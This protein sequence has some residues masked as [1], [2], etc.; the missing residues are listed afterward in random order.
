MYFL[1]RLSIKSKTYLLVLLSVLVALT[2]SA[3]SYRGLGGL[4]AEF[5]DLVFATEIERYTNRLILEEQNYRLNANGSVYDI[6]AANRAYQNALSYVDEIYRILDEIDTLGQSDL[7]LMELEKTRQSTDEYKTLYMKAVSIL[8]EL[9]RQAD[10]LEQEGEYITLQIQQYVEAKRKEIKQVLNQKT[11]EKINNGSNI[12]QYTYVTRLHE[13]KYRLSPDPA[14]L[15]AFRKDYR[16]MMSEWHRLKAMSDQDF[17]FEKLENFYRS[18]KKYKNAMLL[19]AELD[20][21]LVND[22]LPQMKKLGDVV[23]ANAIEAA[24]HSVEHMARKRQTT[25]LTMLVVAIIAIVL[26]VIFGSLIA[27]SISSMVASFQK[28]LLDFFA[29]LNHEKGSVHPI[30]VQGEDEISVMARVVNENIEKIQHVLQRKQDYHQALLEWSKVNYQD[31]N[32]TINRAT[33]LSARALHVERV[34]IWLFSDDESRLQCADLYSRPTNKHEKGAVLAESDYPQYFR[35]IRNLEILAVDDA[36]ND[37]RTRELS[38]DYLEPLGICSMLDLPIVQEGRLI[39]VICHEKTGERKHWE[40][41]ELEFARSLVNAIALSLEIKKRRLIQDELRAQKEILH[42]HANHDALT[43]LPNRFLFDDR[44]NQVIKQ[45][46]RNQGK[47]AIVFIDLDH[48]KGVNDSMGH[49]AGDELLVE[50]AKRLKGRI[51]Q[52]D[53]LARLG[54]DEFTIIMTQV[55]NNDEVVALTQDLL[56]AMAEPFVLQEQ[57]VYVT[58][59]VGVAIYP[60]DGD[61][62]EVLLKNADAAMYQAKEDGR[63]TYQFYTRAMTEKAFERIAMDTS[64]RRALEA[65]EFVVYYQPQVD[66]R[67]GRMTG[68][69]ALVRWRHPAMGMITP[70][71]FLP[72]AYDTGLIVPL[73]LLVMGRAMRQICQWRDQGLDPGRLALNLSI[74]QLQQENFIDT[75]KEL[76]HETGCKPQ[77]IELELTESQIM[78]D[79]SLAAQTLNQI[80]ELGISIAID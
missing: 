39:G 52:T 38:R 47:V 76:L 7:L 46:Q 64:F 31:E 10:T 17:E 79:S 54:G 28:G 45:A 19:W 37:E 80:R 77:W 55:S 9:S 16:F 49:K 60:D 50:V 73:D 72:F 74:M 6:E 23:I 78:K 1:R 18:A 33:E 4:R 27:S 68:V 40:D 12:W 57:T 24:R 61:T 22:V 63:N 29:Y 5:E 67:S 58:L 59:S 13:K 35:A 32:L 62:P 8:T 42:H 65:E 11:I 26:G 36:R 44:L 69:E 2:L 14:V 43:G 66:V 48:F 70:A 56:R 25:A 3:V 21:Q 71:S 53:T 51:R 34:S 75:L 15:N 20:L 30:E 41:D